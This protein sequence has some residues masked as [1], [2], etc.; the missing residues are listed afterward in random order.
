MAR[1]YCVP[2][3]SSVVESDVIVFS[4]CLPVSLSCS[5]DTVLSLPQT[6]SALP[7]LQAAKRKGYTIHITCT[8]L[9][10]H[11][12]MNTNL[13]FPHI[14]LYY[15]LIEWFSIPSKTHIHQTIGKYL[16][17][18]C[19]LQIFLHT[20]THTNHV[21]MISYTVVSHL[22]LQLCLAVLR[23]NFLLPAQC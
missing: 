10:I 12:S 21:T 23:D 9:G 11:L 15:F 20:H 19:Q 18:D 6:S 7:P 22:C 2:G 14:S 5:E 13:N 16:K 4:L 8:P 3:V 17:R 1:C